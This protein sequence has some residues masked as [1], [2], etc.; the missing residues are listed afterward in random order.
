MRRL[1]IITVTI[2]FLI[3]SLS[4]NV[5][6]ATSNPPDIGDSVVLMDAATGDILYGKNIDSAYPPASTTKT[7]TALLTLEKCKLDDVV[8]I[9]N[10]FV[11][12]NLPLLDGNTICI[13][14]G[15]Q[16]T[17]RDLLHALILRSANDAAVALAIHISGSVPEFVNLMNKRAAELGC[18]T[19]HFMN[20][21]G[22][23]NNDH[24]L[25]ARDL[26]LIMRE[27][28]TH[29]DFRKIAS[30]LTYTIQPT[31][32]TNADETSKNRVLYNE[33]KLINKGSCYYYDGA[34]GGKT[35][36]TIQSLF[37][38]VACASRNGHRLI[39]A[40]VHDKD[41]DY[42]QC[43]RELF[44]Y[45]FN[46][47]DLNKLYS[48]GDTVKTTA[49]SDGT[50]ISL[51]ASEDFYYVSKKGSSSK[52]TMAFTSKNLNKKQFKKGDIVS[53]VTFTMDGNNVGT[54]DLKSGQSYPAPIKLSA[55]TKTSNTK[56]IIVTI[57]ALVLFCAYVFKRSKILIRKKRRN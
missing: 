10:D 50:K 28:S 15:E 43:T 42:F 35:G 8:T 46:N 34:E 51:I 26:A 49:A 27:L 33:N 19:A 55:I 14:D 32:K 1:N 36:Y 54:L 13:K 48:K 38:Y 11:N 22:L 40:I 45:G 9:S 20:P 47:F 41:K 17:V 39:A 12:K 24:K 31:N 5:K 37:S 21:N 16:L 25:S 3:T 7:M 53:K 18:K 6:A 30:T 44:D 29:E 2:I 56:Y 52:P 57:A 4:F 23:Y